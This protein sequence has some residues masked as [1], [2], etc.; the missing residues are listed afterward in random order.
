MITPISILTPF[1]SRS[2]YNT[3]VISTNPAPNLHLKKIAQIHPPHISIILI[4]TAA[5][6]FPLNV[7][8]RAII[9][10]EISIVHRKH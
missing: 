3:A 5:A 10:S 7:F 6:L 4:I 1:F 2:R 9:I 8:I